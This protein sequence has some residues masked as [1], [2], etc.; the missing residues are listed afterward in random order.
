MEDDVDL[1][2]LCV[3]LELAKD[4]KINRALFVV[5]DGFVALH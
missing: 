3:V 4:V 5:G 1:Q 2:G